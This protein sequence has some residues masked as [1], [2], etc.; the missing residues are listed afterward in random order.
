MSLWLPIVVS[1]IAV[2][3]A[4][5]VVHMVFSY[6]RSDFKGV[7]S[8][9]E[10]MKSLREAGVPPGEYVIPYCAS[11][12]EMNEPEFVKKVEE[13]PV[14]MLTVWPGGFEMGKSLGLWFV[15]CLLMGVFVAYMTGRALAPAA[16]YLEVFRIAGASAFGAYALALMQNSIW[17]KRGWSS[18]FKSMFDGLIYA[19]LTAGVFGWLWPA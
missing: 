8:E 9:D 17:F 18:T 13:G 12:K 2:F 16:H 10:L 1:A 19:V 11:P 7:P 5:S 14:A 15:Y 4:S 3:A 6:H